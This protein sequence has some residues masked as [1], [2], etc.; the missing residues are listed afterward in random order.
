MKESN[1][2]K[3]FGWW[4]GM[5]YGEPSDKFEDFKQFKNTIPKEKIIAHI[6]SCEIWYCPM[7]EHH[8]IF[9]GEVIKEAGEYQDGDFLFPIDFLRYY[10]TYDIGIPP[11]YEEYLKSIG[12][13]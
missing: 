12:V 10:E 3:L 11:E 4:D 9:T 8:D 5:P 7:P 1:G 2:Y 6:K 13:G